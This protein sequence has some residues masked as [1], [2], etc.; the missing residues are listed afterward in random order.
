MP[1]A[2]YQVDFHAIQKNVIIVPL[3]FDL[4]LH[5][6]VVGKFVLIL[7]HLIV[8]HD[9]GSFWPSPP[10]AASPNFQISIEL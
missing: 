8:S 7:S 1:T 9:Y 4:G 3:R 10:S 5:G 2:H 6:K